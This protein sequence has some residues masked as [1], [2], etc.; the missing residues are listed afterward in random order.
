[1]TNAITTHD[2]HGN[3]MLSRWPVI[4]H[5]HQDISDHRFE[6]RGL[7]HSVIDIQGRHVHHQP[8]RFPVVNSSEQHSAE[9]SHAIPADDE[10]GHRQWCW[11]WAALE[12]AV[13]PATRLLL[14]CH[15]HNPVGRGLARQ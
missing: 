1:M 15:P 7:L 8:V 4:Q 5:Q 10:A 11:D 9:H 3:A 2:E 14:L 13:T 6:Q 12:A